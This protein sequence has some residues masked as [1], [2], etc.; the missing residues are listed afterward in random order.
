MRREN[1][2]LRKLK[3]VISINL[4]MLYREK[5]EMVDKHVIR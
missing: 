2:D 5:S 4:I 3:L 1:R